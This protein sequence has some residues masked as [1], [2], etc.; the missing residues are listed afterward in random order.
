VKKIKTVNNIATLIS[1]KIGRYVQF[2]TFF[3]NPL[4]CEIPALTVE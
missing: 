1:I 4:H 3:K 2:C